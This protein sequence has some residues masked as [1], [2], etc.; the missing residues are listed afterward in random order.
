VGVAYETHNV[1]LKPGGDWEIYIE[2]GLN[3][4]LNFPAGVVVFS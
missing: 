1:R 4:L 3:G 2:G